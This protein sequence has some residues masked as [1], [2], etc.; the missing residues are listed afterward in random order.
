MNT[1][2]GQLILRL[3]RRDY[4]N[5]LTLND[6]RIIRMSKR[7]ESYIGMMRKTIKKEAAEQS[8]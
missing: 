6:K 7:Q 1:K 4:D 8:Q 5:V 2:L 3:L